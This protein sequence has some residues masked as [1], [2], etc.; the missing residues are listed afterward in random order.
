[1]ERKGADPRPLSRRSQAGG[2]RDIAPIECMIL[3]LRANDTDAGLPRGAST[4][5]GHDVP[6][7]LPLVSV[8]IH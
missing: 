1:M 2:C 7:S 3:G 4:L 8:Q 5:S 6:L